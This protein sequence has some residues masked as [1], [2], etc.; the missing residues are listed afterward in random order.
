[1]S[2]QLPMSMAGRHVGPL[3]VERTSTGPVTVITVRGELTYGTTQPLTDLV[4]RVVQD[5]APLRVVLDLTDVTFCCSAGIH[6]LLHTREQVTAA[7]GHLVLHQPSRPVHRVLLITG[8]HRHFDI[9][10]TEADLS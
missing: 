5:E 7:A 2:S 3:S 9:R 10:H 8:D 4:D 1:M 6:A